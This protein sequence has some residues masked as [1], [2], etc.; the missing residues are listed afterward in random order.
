[1]PHGVPSKHSSVSLCHRHHN[2]I[3]V[4]A[5]YFFCILDI[6]TWAYRIVGFETR[7]SLKRKYVQ[8]AR[9]VMKKATWNKVKHRCLDNLDCTLVWHKQRLREHTLN[10]VLFTSSSSFDVWLDISGPRYCHPVVGLFCPISALPFSTVLRIAS[11]IVRKFSKIS[12]PLI[13]ES[14][15]MGYATRT[16]RS[17]SGFRCLK[18]RGVGGVDMVPGVASWITWSV[19]GRTERAG[20]LL[21]RMCQGK[22]TECMA[23][24]RITRREGLA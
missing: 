15:T 5:I 4:V 3:K 12:L 21:A 20:V 9:G 16:T 19:S 2:K 11:R 23:E 7:I 24:Y 17:C 22:S 13:M 14:I 1:M 10:S 8:M 18:M 6:M